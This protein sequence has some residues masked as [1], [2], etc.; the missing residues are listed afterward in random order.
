LILNDSIKVGEQ[1]KTRREAG[2][3]GSRTNDVKRL[4][5]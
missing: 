3:H 5:L 1:Q 2:F 4:R